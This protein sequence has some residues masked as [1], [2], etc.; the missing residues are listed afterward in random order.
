[1]PHELSSR[2]TI[3]FKF[4]VPALW[5]TLVGLATAAMFVI[6][7]AVRPPA[8]PEIK[9]LML[10]VWIGASTFIW[11][12]CCRLKRVCVDGATLHISNYF[13]ED[14]VPLAS[15]TAVR[16]NRWVN[17]RPVTVEFRT[18]TAFG[19]RIVFMPRVCW[20][21]FWRPHPVA[22]ELRALVAEAR[23]R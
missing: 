4:V 18:P 20:F 22:L 16:E 13:R 1:M 15:I 23:R 7:F 8:P 9:W 21:L 3:A 17:I 10:A 14:R 19:Q 11:W 2:L 6:S 5:I 12:M